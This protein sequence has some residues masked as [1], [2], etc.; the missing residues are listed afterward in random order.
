LGEIAEAIRGVTFSGG[1]TSLEVFPEGVA[2]LTTSGVQDDVN[3]SSR[4]FIPRR[5]VSNSKQLLR[6][7]DILISTANSKEL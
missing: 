2:C 7:N 3:W 1:E 5:S 4:R 6:L